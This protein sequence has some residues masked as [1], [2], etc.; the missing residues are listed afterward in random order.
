MTRTRLLLMLIA[1]LLWPTQAHAARGFW[2][3]LE[4]LSGPGPFKGGL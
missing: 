1:V 4:E 2:G 3:W